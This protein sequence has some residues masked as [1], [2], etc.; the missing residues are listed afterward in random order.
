MT[1]QLCSDDDGVTT[2]LEFD[3]IME[4]YKEEREIIIRKNAK[5]RSMASQMFAHIMVHLSEES[6]ATVKEADDWDEIE[7]EEDPVRLWNRVRA[8]HLTTT[9]SNSEL[10]KLRTRKLYNSLK[11]FKN[12]SLTS[13]KLHATNALNVLEAVQETEPSAQAQAQAQAMDFI[14]RLD[15]SKFADLQKSLE[16]NVILGTGSYPKTL[17]EAYTIAQNI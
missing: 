15:V 1:G 4:D 10:D 12:E 9:S 7:T 5:I 6:S 13:F 8:T 16:N 14:S 3:F 17:N 11:R 2:E